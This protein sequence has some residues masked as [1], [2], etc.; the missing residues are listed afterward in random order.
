MAASMKNAYIIFLTEEDRASAVSVLANEDQII[1]LSDEI[2]CVSLQALALL[3]GSNIRYMH[4]TSEDV[5]R[6]GLRTWRFAH[7]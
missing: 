1:T 2:F 5:T 7:P 4:A 3:D 6:V